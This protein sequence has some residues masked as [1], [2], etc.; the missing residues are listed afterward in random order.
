MSGERKRM[1]L[2]ELTAAVLDLPP[3]ERALLIERVEDSLFHDDIDPVVLERARQSMADIKSGRVKSVPA[4]EVLDML[5]KPTVVELASAAMHISAGGRAELVDRLIA[6]LAGNSGYDP[7][8]E[9]EMNRR[10][11]EIEAGTA[12][13][14]SEE[15]FFAKLSARRHARQVS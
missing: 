14:L 12:K 10:I 8:W 2:D 3:Q 4:D 13:T 5:E 1:S 6:S 9:A 7:A 11:E 15:E